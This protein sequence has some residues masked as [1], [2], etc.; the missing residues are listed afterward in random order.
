MASRW[1]TGSPASCRTSPRPS[2]RCSQRIDWRGLVILLARLRRAGRARSLRPDRAEDICSAPT[3]T[4]RGQGDRLPRAGAPKLRTDSVD[5]AGCRSCLSR[6]ATGHLAGC[7]M[8]CR[9]TEF[10]A[11]S[12]G[13]VEFARLP[14]DHPLY[15]MYSSGTT[16]LPKCM[17]HGAGGTLLQHSRSWYCTLT[18]SATTGCSTSPPW[19]DDVELADERARSRSDDRAVRR[20]AVSARSRAALGDGGGGEGH[21]IRHQC[22]SIS[23]C[24]RRR[25]S[26]PERSHDLSALRA[27]LSTGSP[28]ALHSFD[29]VYSKV[30]HDVHLASISGGTDIVS[31]FAGGNPIAPVYR[32]ELQCRALGDGG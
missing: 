5:R 16:G 32:G 6:Q 8:R 9:G 17:V 25:G 21:R 31:C 29:Y 27:I 4:V 19:L 26:S 14:F 11:S 1:A 15:I 30:K 13:T 23:R 22:A 10:G 20:R 2:S 24:A 18:S 28:L 3:A 7:R 12:W